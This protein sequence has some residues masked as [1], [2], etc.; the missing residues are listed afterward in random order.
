MALELR[1]FFSPTYKPPRMHFVFAR[2]FGVETRKRS[3]SMRL[4][5]FEAGRESVQYFLQ[6]TPSH[7]VVEPSMRP[8]NSAQFPKRTQDWRAGTFRMDGV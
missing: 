8:S 4:T 2:E 1:V 7:Q 5:Q 6:S 3:T